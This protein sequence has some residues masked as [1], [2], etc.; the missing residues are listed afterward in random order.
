MSNNQ[1]RRPKR[2]LLSDSSSSSSEDDE[3]YRDEVHEKPKLTRKTR[4]SSAAASPARSMLKDQGTD[5]ND[6]L[7]F[8]DEVDDQRLLRGRNRV[9]QAKRQEMEVSVENVDD[10]LEAESAKGKIPSRGGKSSK[11]TVSKP[12]VGKSATVPT[13]SI[14]KSLRFENK[15]VS[16]TGIKPLSRIVHGAVRKDVKTVVDLDDDESDSSWPS[17]TAGGKRK[18]NSDSR[19][20][21]P[22]AKKQRPSQVAPSSSAA[23]T[24]SSSSQKSTGKSTRAKKKTVSLSTAPVIVIDD[25]D[26][27]EDIESD[28]E[29]EVQ[30]KREGEKK[31]VKSTPLLSRT[32][33]SSSSTPSSDTIHKNDRD[34]NKAPMSAVKKNV[35]VEEGG[36][37]V[38]GPLKK[39]ILP[40]TRARTRSADSPVPNPVGAS[41]KPS[42]TS[43]TKK[44]ATLDIDKT[45]KRSSSASSSSASSA[46]TAHA[47]LAGGTELWVDKYQPITEDEIAVHKRKVEDV[48][49]WFRHVFEVA[50]PL[51][52][53]KGS[54]SVFPKLL[55]LTGPSGSGKT[56]V[57]RM[58]SMELGFEIVEWVNPIN[59][60]TIV[61]ME[62]VAAD[63]EERRDDGN[64]YYRSIPNRYT[65]ITEKFREFLDCARKRPSLVFQGLPVAGNDSQPH[66]QQLNNPTLS[67]SAPSSSSSSTRTPPRKIILVEDLPNITN[68]T[69][70]K[71]FHSAV[72]SY[73]DS[74][75]SVFPLV[76]IISDTT[77]PPSDGDLGG[78]GRSEGGGGSAVMTMRGLIPAEV[79][80][81]PF[82]TQ[83]S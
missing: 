77:V 47:G 29:E 69:T 83:I 31:A 37:T 62:D 12:A 2:I 26:P 78:G 11:R 27:L 71:A 63:E 43:T 3:N 32:S 45:E 58:L 75:R 56:A 54:K 28:F 8:R 22:P 21:E 49:G 57:V 23:A 14:T 64:G 52:L 4:G 81:S 76:F 46:D 25:D 7:A 41:R 17:S 35:V 65:S 61:S 55:I 74:P 66:K 10:E 15:V 82:A 59:V 9:K 6:P 60:N 19:S 18:P 5:W 51:A 13:P 38:D 44:K 24:T 1:R 30:G 73:L 16:S 34:Q 40:L 72:R 36:T 80:G 50:Q 53:R 20:I 68:L 79:L 33:S 42:K 39:W 70:R 67:S 48:R